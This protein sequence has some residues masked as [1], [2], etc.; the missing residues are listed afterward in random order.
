M[1][2]GT[3]VANARRI[4]VSWIL[5]ATGWVLVRRALDLLWLGLPF[6]WLPSVIAELAPKVTVLDVAAWCVSLVF[7]GGASLMTFR[8]LSGGERVTLRVAISAARRRWGSMWRIGLLCAGPAALG[9]LLF[10]VPGVAW[11]TRCAAAFSV[12]MVEDKKS[13][14]A[15]VRS[16]TLSQGS[17]WQ[18][19]GLLGIA[20]LGIVAIYGAALAMAALATGPLGEARADLI[21]RFGLNPLADMFVY[22]IVTVG[23]AAVYTAMRD[24]EESLPDVFV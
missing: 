5:R 15:F 19:A 14:D 6:V 10:V 16:Q 22:A 13:G 17:R 9:L 12:A 1:A 24:A 18:V 3:I 20:A 23:S 21:L 7:V 4:N 2:A 8:E 11:M